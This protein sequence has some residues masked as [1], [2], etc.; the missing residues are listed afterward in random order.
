MDY[1]GKNAKVTV[2]VRYS[3]LIES[4]LDSSDTYS[5]KEEEK[6]NVLWHLE[7]YAVIFKKVITLF[8]HIYFYY[9][10]SN[11]IKS[12]MHTCSSCN[13][14]MKIVFVTAIIQL[15][16]HKCN[17]CRFFFIPSWTRFIEYNETI[18]YNLSKWDYI[19]FDDMH[20]IVKW[21]LSKNTAITKLRKKNLF[22]TW[23]LGEL[24]IRK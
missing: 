5:Q 11:E 20:S 10:N 9:Y 17:I 12:D 6:E 23:I 7:T 1:R 4:N 14:A 2:D 3:L 15:L 18:I 22:T 13:Y 8:H 21:N 16:Q 24:T 19:N